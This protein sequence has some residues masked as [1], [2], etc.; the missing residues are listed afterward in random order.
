MMDSAW[1]EPTLND[2]KAVAFAQNHIG[3]RHPH[4]VERDV[5]V[6]MG[7]IIV[8]KHREHAADGNTA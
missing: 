1:T 5:A 7:G 3:Y 2:L 8:T 4:I 6:P